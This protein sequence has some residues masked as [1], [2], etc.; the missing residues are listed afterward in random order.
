MKTYSTLQVL[1]ALC[2]F[3]AFVACGSGGDDDGN[4]SVGADDDDDDNNDDDNDDDDNNDNNDDNDDNDNDDNDNDDDDT[5][6]VPSYPILNVDAADGTEFKLVNR[7]VPGSTGDLWANAW[8][9]DDRLYT[10]NGDGFGFGR[11]FGEVV[12][13]VVE[14]EPPNLE[15]Q[16]IPGA[17]GAYVAAKWG[18]EHWKYSRKPTGLVCVDGN[19]Y[20]FYQNLANFLTE[21]PFGDAPHGSIS[22]T[23]DLGETWYVDRS[24]PMFTDHVFTTGFFLDYGKC[25]QHAVDEYT[26]VYGLDYNWRFA[27]DFDQTK[28]FL[29][30]VPSDSIL[31]REDWE[32]VAGFDGDA[33]IWSADIEDKVPV[34]EDDTL[35][36]HDYSGIGQGSVI[37]LPELNRYLY[38]TR[39]VYEWIFYEAPQP[40]GPWTK[41]TVQSW[42]GGWTE[43]FHPGYPAIF[44]SRYL[45]GDSRGGWLISSLSDSWFDGTYYSMCWRRFDLE[46]SETPEY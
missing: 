36:T 15:G 21:E 16:A 26:Y 10:A 44:A 5:A 18:P 29:A 2:L 43:T 8:G 25:Q 13:N 19:L 31:N 17:Y 33:P 4:S 14:G 28:L 42:T 1:V 6:P 12:L 23:P 46:V 20:M 30:R 41:I 40:W 37:F 24:Q 45:D 3:L 7:W 11:V 22:V 35:Y 32:F 39:A 27:E 38:S 9:P 34:I